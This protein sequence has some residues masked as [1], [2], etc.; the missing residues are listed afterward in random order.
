MDS[1]KSWKHSLGI[2]LRADSIVMLSVPADPLQMLGDM[3][4]YPAGRRDKRDA[5]G[6]QQ[7][8]GMLWHLSDAHLVSRGLGNHSRSI[9]PPLSACTGSMGSFCVCQILTL[10]P[11]CCSRNRDSSD[12][13]TVF[14]SAVI[15]FW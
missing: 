15:E 7:C 12:H 9:I 3:V 8:L 14:Q 4:H 10:A 1:T 11:K 2:L 13:A 5:G 6:Q